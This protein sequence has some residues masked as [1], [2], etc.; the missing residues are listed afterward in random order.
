[1]PMDAWKELFTTDVGLLSLGVILF[2][3]GMAFWFSR[4][5]SKKIDEEARNRPK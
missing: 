5:F 3:I 2:T 4:W 1:M